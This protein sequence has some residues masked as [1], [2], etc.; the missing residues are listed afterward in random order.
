MPIDRHAASEYEDYREQAEARI[1]SRDPDDW[2]T[3]ALALDK[4]LHRRLGQ[5]LELPVWTQEPRRPSP[6]FRKFA[7]AESR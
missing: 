1:A 7:L 4:D 5:K 3:V 6:T 2:P